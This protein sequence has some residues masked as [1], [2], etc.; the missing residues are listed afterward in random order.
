[1]FKLVCLPYPITI[2]PY[3]VY[4]VQYKYCI[5]YNTTSAESVFMIMHKIAKLRIQRAYKRCLCSS[6]KAKLQRS[7]DI[8]VDFYQEPFAFD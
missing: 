3:T 1:M 5:Q 4:T 6:F 7:G 2:I 8:S